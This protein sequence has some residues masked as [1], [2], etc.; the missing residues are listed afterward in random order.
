VTFRLG[1]LAP[2]GYHLGDRQLTSF[3]AHP[4][5]MAVVVALLAGVVGMLSLTEARG[6]A[7]IGVLVSVTTIP[8]VANVGVATAYGEWSEVGGAALQLVLN[9][10]ALVIAGVVTL[11]V[12]ARTTGPGRQNARR[13]GTLRP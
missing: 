7:L 1:H 12:Q 3:I 8:A 9:V 4:D 13:R 2:E 10:T 6:G 5:G 11:A